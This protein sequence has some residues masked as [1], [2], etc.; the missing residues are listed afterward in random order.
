MEEYRQIFFDDPEA[1]R[2][3]QSD[4]GEETIPDRIKEKPLDTNSCKLHYENRKFFIVI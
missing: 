1:V 2:E 4:D 3:S